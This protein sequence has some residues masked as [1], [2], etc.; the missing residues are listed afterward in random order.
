MK[1][2]HNARLTSILLH[3][4]QTVNTIRTVYETWYY[5]DET[6][7]FPYLRYRKNP[8]QKYESSDVLHQCNNMY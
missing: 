2:N 1:H 8:W 4:A 5:N 7:D 3:L 6:F